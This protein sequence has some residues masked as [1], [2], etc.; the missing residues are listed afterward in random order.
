[1]NGDYVIAANFAID[2][3]TLTYSAGAGGTITAP[4]SSPT[5]HNYGASVTITASPSAGYHF[6]NWTGDVATVANVNAASTTITMNGD[7]TITANFALDAITYTLTY[8]AGTGG[9]ITAPASSPTTHNSGSVV[10]ITASPA[11]GYHFV[12]WTGDVGTVANVNAASTTIT[13]NGDYVIAANFATDTATFSV[14]LVPGWNLVSFNLHPVSTDI[15]DVLSSI[16]GS[17]DLVYAWDATTGWMKYD[18]GAP[19][20][21]ND[22]N[23]LDETMGFWIK[24][25]TADTLDVS[26]T[27]PVTSNIELKT[28]WNLV[29]FP[30]T[31]SLGLP[32]ALSTHGVGSDFTL[33]YAYHANDTGDLWKLFDQAAPAWANDLTAL[34]SGWGYWVKVGGPHTWDV[35]Y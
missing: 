31:G 30:S 27:A 11:T 18:P 5:T 8:S 25:K 20:Y 29:S 28:G 24:M 16:S 1:M 21:S 6:V 12:N 7:Y 10:T 14:A 26:G 35:S 19:V 23:D 9:T 15:T 2:T 13:M 22:L 17:Y 3:H 33:V 34:S 4:A 32:G